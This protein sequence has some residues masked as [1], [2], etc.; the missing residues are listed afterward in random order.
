MRVQKRMLKKIATNSFYKITVDTEQNLLLMEMCGY[1]G[2][3]AN[4]PEF[5]NDCKNAAIYLQPRFN[6]LVDLTQTT[7]ISEDAIAL[8]QE[9]QRFFKAA[10]LGK[11]AE[12]HRQDDPIVQ[13]QT[14]GMTRTTGLAKQ[15]QRFTERTV[16]MTW[17]LQPEDNKAGFFD[18]FKKWFKR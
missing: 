7:A 14:S 18:S 13:Y 9:A 17:L 15:V 6:I 3:R 8:H 16:A 2:S 11:V 4:V 12:I 1:W 5:L 10:G